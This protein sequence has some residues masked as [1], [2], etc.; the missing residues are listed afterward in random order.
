MR[1]YKSQLR[2]LNTGAAIAL[3]GGVVFVATNGGS[4][5][6]ALTDKN[7]VALT[8]PL[9]LN[10]GSFDFYVADTVPLVDLY[11]LTPTGH[12]VTSKN[13]KPSG[14]AS[15]SYDHKVLHTTLVIPFNAAD[16]LAD[17]TETPTGF[18]LPGA[19]QPNPAVDLTTIHAAKTISF[20][21]LS[22]AGGVAA[23]FGTG[24]SV[25]T[26]GYIKATIANAGV[27]IGTDLYVQD[28][29]NAGDHTIEQNVDKIGKQVTYTLL[30]GT[31]T[32]A[33]FIILPVQLRV[34]AL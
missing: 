15:I 22:T 10:N 26:A 28:S 23:G 31:T 34:S 17:A 27:T 9:V 20:G 8:N 29:A 21:T 18:I 25:G 30:T 32:A 13:L 3:A 14:D 11:I 24:L 16:Q 12:M 33:G 7:G 19:V 1:H 2:S 4:Q 5:K 6:V